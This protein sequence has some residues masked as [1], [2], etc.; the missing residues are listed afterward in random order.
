MID[1]DSYM[2]MS[3]MVRSAQLYYRHGEQQSRIA[4]ILGIPQAKVSRLLKQ[5]RENEYIKINFNFP[6]ILD[7]SV[8]LIERF[9][10]RDAI[11]APTGEADHLKE[12]LG[13]AAARYFE[14]IVGNGAKIGLSCGHTLYQMVAQI[15][16][17]GKENLEI[18]PLASDST[19]E[20]VD[21]FPNTLVGLLAAKYRPN[22]KAHALP[23]QILATAPNVEKWRK[24]ILAS[25]AGEIFASAHN[26]D[27]AFSGLGTINNDTPG[28]CAFAEQNGFPLKEIKK[29]GAVAEYN[30][31]PIDKDGVSL[32]DKPELKK[33]KRFQEITNRIL[34]VRLDTFRKLSA[35]HG[36]YI[37]CIAGGETKEN[38][39]R[40]VLKA[41][42]ANV[43]ITDSETAVKLL[44][45]N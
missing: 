36:K 16:E 41:K 10:L 34:N 45:D 2:E 4:E 27:V 8:K 1:F 3:E 26:V 9:N 15:R 35:Q 25:R 22:V 21:L 5:A 12:D 24:E 14:R 40:A 32:A 39:I 44:N 30:Y 7:L 13:W 43:L 38:G 37:V 18:F 17:G 29:L 28:F 19:Y 23:A 20:S 33:D 6:A 31:V 11:V 42:L